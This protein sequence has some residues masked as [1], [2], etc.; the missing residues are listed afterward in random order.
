MAGCVIRLK[1]KESRVF[2]LILTGRVGMCDWELGL[3]WSAGLDIPG[4]VHAVGDRC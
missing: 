2:H 4:N 1:T 3:S